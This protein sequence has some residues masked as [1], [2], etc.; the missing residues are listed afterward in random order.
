M[1]E[2]QV[3]EE[4][5]K[6]SRENKN[7]IA[8][9]I[10]DLNKFPRE[11]NP[12]SVFMAGSPGAGKTEASQALLQ[13]FSSQYTNFSGSFNVVRIDADELRSE[14][15]TF[16][17]ANSNSF[18]AAVSILVDC[19]HDLVLAQSQSFI[20][21]GTLSNFAKAEQNIERSLKRNRTVQIYYVYQAPLQA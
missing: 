7:E 13:R 12:V 20:L 21:D 14:F 6:Y 5:I 8:K 1:N 17:G 10:A 3:R 16:T 15:R 19:I 2:N 18:Q 9:K 4:A 11:T